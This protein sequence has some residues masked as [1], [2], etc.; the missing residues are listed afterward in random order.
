M[1]VRVGIGYVGNGFGALAGMEGRISFNL[2]TAYAS[3]LVGT[4]IA[5]YAC[6]L[7][8]INACDLS[9]QLILLELY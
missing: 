6:R 5:G 3:F 4:P 8:A 2:P 7:S 1:G 9:A